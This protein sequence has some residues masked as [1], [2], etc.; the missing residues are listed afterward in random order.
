M[1]GVIRSARSIEQEVATFTQQA[2]ASEDEYMLVGAAPKGPVASVGH[3]LQRFPAA[4]QTA[5][6]LRCST[7]PMTVVAQSFLATGNFRN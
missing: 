2:V 1:R 4:K 6:T 3:R 5:A 7:T